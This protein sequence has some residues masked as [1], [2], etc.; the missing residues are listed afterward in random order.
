MLPAKRLVRRGT[1][2]LSRGRCFSLVS[3]IHPR[4]PRRCLATAV[5]SQSDFAMGLLLNDGEL[6]GSNYLKCSWKLYSCTLQSPHERLDS[7][8]ATCTDASALVPRDTNTQSTAEQGEDGGLT[9][10]E[11][12]HGRACDSAIRSAILS[13]FF[14]SNRTCVHQNRTAVS[15]SAM[16]SHFSSTCGFRLRSPPDRRGRV[17][18]ARH[19]GI[20]SSTP[21]YHPG[22]SAFYEKINVKSR[23]RR[24]RP[25][26]GVTY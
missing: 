11:G 21:T 5:P 6:V 10:T 3:A 4:H 20:L 25:Y 23:S 19:A 16:R 8:G 1:A 7:R 9:R 17:A 12:T 2:V 18:H 24:K 26:R 14:H 13:H 22:Q 15:C